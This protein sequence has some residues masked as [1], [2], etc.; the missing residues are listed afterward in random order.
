ML[1]KKENDSKDQSRRSRRSRRP[2]RIMRKWVFVNEKRTA[3]RER[4]HEM[5][6]MDEDFSKKVNPKDE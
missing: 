4:K 1:L 6:G 3:K 2:P 5:K